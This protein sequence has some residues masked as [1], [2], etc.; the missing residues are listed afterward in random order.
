MHRIS[1]RRSAALALTVLV[2]SLPLSM[3]AGTGTA[4]NE[5]LINSGLAGWPVPVPFGP[6]GVGVV[7]GISDDGFSRIY[8]RMPDG[9]AFDLESGEAPRFW[10]GTDADPVLVGVVGEHNLVDLNNDGDELDMLLATSTNGRPFLPIV[11]D[12]ITLDNSQP[13]TNCTT[14]ISAQL[15][16]ACLSEGDASDDVNS[17][18]DLAD[19]E[20]VLIHGDGSITRP[21]R[22]IDNDAGDLLDRTVT[23]LPDGSVSVGPLRVFPNG[24]ITD[25]DPVVNDGEVVAVVGTSRLLRIP[26]PV[27]QLTFGL[28]TAGGT[29]IPLNEGSLHRQVGNTVWVQVDRNLCRLTPT[30]TT[31]CLG[32][33][34]GLGLPFSVLG[35]DWAAFPGFYIAGP[36]SSSNIAHLVLPGQPAQSVSNIEIPMSSTMNAVDLGAGAGMLLSTGSG[37][38]E[39]MLWIGTAGAVQPSPGADPDTIVSLQD[40]RALVN[41]R[42][43]AGTDYNGDGDVSDS[44]T[45]LFANG[46]LTNLRVTAHLDFETP[47]RKLAV[48]FDDGGGVLFAIDE[49]T[50]GDRNGDGD[51]SDLVAALY[52]GASV[53][54]LA[55]AVVPDGQADLYDRFATTGGHTA[56]LGVWEPG[57]G[58]D[59]DGNS[60]ISGAVAFALSYAPAEPAPPYQPL[61]PSRL[62]DTRVDGPQVGYTGV[63]PVAGQTIEVTAPAGSGAVALNVTGLNASLTGFVTV[64]PCGEAVPTASNL[65][66]SPGMITPNMVISKVGANGKV[67]I[68]T[69]RS[70][71]LVV[72]LAGSFPAGAAYT[73]LTPTRVLDTRADGPQIGYTGAK[74]I[75]GQTIE[76]TA[77][78]GVPAVVVN[79]T[80]LDAEQVGFVTVYPC[81]GTLPTVSNLNLSPGM[82]TPNMVIT[83][84]GA[85]GKVCIFT[86]RSANLIADLAGTF[87]AGS[88]YTALQPSRVLDTRTDGPQIGYTGAQ[89]TAGQIIEVTA[90]IGASAVVM[91]VTGLNAEADGFVTVYSCGTDIPTA[92]NLNLA[93]GRI[94]PNLTIT[95]VGANGKVCIFTQRSANLIADLAGTFP[96]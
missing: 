63:K 10:M 75:T 52:D 2:G 8:Q 93:P 37:A 20:L 53:V 38:G 81:G 14:R 45:H 1:R 78:F 44:I 56:L 25:I 72:D 19:Y 60:V 70:A 11:G 92:S 76:V 18:G 32:V 22:F 59:L 49:A 73:P 94:T 48:V 34:T 64:Y 3:D 66:L 83:K 27:A 21:G 87:P 84:V 15:A 54:N 89:P 31:G 47:D 86:Q 40:G 6:P 28:L 65:N 43:H 55:V 85:N 88:Q 74:P 68:F 17:D 16:V 67:C 5:T 33:G 26:V 80:G 30:G 82:I 91:N 71:D 57:E 36:N 90:P 51:A 39:Q 13:V 58:E 9:S 69:Q 95:K 24:T 7:R 35:D 62:L 23:V 4:A 41:L 12:P 96:A 61:T 29:L 79:V 42:E 50:S 46:T 77:P